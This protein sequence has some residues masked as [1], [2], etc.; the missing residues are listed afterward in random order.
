MALTAPIHKNRTTTMGRIS[1]YISSTAIFN[2][3]NLWSEL[4]EETEDFTS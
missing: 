1:G 3:V 2:N 4:Y